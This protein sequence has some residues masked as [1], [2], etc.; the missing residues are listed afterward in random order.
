MANSTL[1]RLYVVD[2]SNPYTPSIVTY[3]SDSSMIE[4]SS[5]RNV[6]VD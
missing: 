3:F 6:F 4:L 5:V 1:N 2:I